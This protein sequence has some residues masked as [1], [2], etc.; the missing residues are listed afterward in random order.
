MSKIYEALRRH[1]RAPDGPAAAA[2]RPSV[3]R[4]QLARALESV[5]PIVRRL[6]NDAGHGIV[7]H[8]VSASEGEGVSTL[9]AE[10]ALLVASAGDW[11]VLLLDGDKSQLATAAN[12]GCRTEGGLVDQVEAGAPL[13]GA[14]TSARD[15][16]LQVGVLAGRR[17]P[18]VAQKAIAGLYDRLRAEYELTVIDCPAVFS[19][20]YLELAPEAADGVVLVVQAERNRP[21]II[22]EAQ[23]QIVEGGG[24]LI[25]SILNRRHTYIPSFLYRLL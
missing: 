8:F 20:H 2:D 24:K 1:E 19:R 5:F 12:F 23:S 17:S 18:A 14:I 21:A 25:G 7:L 11:R 9:S 16:R 15:S 13:E 22:R 6:H 10:F 3:P 4:G